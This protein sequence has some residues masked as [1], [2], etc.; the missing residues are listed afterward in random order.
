MASGRLLKHLKTLG[1]GRPHSKF[2]AHTALL[3]LPL[4][5]EQAVMGHT[6]GHWVLQAGQTWVRGTQWNKDKGLELY[7]RPVE[8]SIL[9]S[10]EGGCGMETEDEMD[11]LSPAQ[12]ETGHIPSPSLS[13][14]ETITPIK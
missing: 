14:G 4:P 7:S 2:P 1:T 6:E 5:L 13:S 12:G 10:D 3:R 11:K 9:T 8:S